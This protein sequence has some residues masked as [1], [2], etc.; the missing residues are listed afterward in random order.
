M[1]GRDK[2]NRRS[3]REPK[4]LQ[5]DPEKRTY[6][7]SP[8]RND[9]IRVPKD[10]H[11]THPVPPIPSDVLK[12]GKSEIDKSNSGPQNERNWQRVPTLHKRSAQDLPRRKSSKKRKEDHDR[13][14]E[15]KAM[16][17]SMPTR[18][19][20][21][22]GVAGRPMKRE[23]KKMR[24]GLGRN[25]TNPSSDISL[26]VPESVHSS[27]SS[28]SENHTSY[29]LKGIDLLS[30]RPT[31]R[32]SE[33]PHNT[34]LV[35]GVDSQRSAARRLP[36]R[37]QISEEVLNANKR[38]DDLADDLDA[39]SLR[40][41][42]E[43]DQRR[44]ERKKLS[45]QRRTERKIAKKA[46]KQRLEEVAAARAGNPPPKNMERGVL[47]REVVGLGIDDAPS[48][49]GMKSSDDNSRQQEKRPADADIEEPTTTAQNP[50]NDFHRSASLAPTEEAG[51]PVDEEDL[52]IATAQVARLS[53]ASMSS[54]SSPR[55]HARGASNISEMMDLSN[56]CAPVEKPEP[57]RKVS[58]ETNIRQHQSWTAFFR[59]NTKPKRNSTPTSFS[60][61]SRET[62]PTS[63]PPTSV[64]AP[65]ASISTGVPKRTMSRFREDLP[66]L[67]LSP[68]DSRVQSPEA[69]IVPPIRTGY[70]EK[71]GGGRGSGENPIN[72]A[73]I[74]RHDT[75]TSG[76]RS[77]E[78]ASRNRNET[79]TSGHR[80]DIP[81]PEPS[82]IMS[83]SLASIDSEGSW[84]SG[85]PRASSKHN[86]ALLQPLRDSTSSLHKRFKEYGESQEELGIAEDEYFSRLTPGPEEEFGKVSKRRASGNPMPSS[87]EE[88]GDS[89]AS[90]GG[91]TKWGAVG[92]QPTVVHHA[93]RAKSREVLL[94]DYENDSMSE[95]RGETPQELFDRKS[96]GFEGINK[97]LPDDP[98]ISRASSVNLSKGHARHISAGSA[99]LLDLKPRVSGESKRLSTERP[100]KPIGAEV[101]EA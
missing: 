10:I 57:S 70:P 7:F 11:R 54:P 77:L 71:K 99:R 18:A 44:R 52:M 45:D 51:S 13:E 26:P 101:Q 41:L 25:F 23:S 9:T 2:S 66:E 21:E 3:G 20:T 1:N 5:R 28:S 14:A 47:G 68:P 34:Q 30:P 64:Y 91:S 55:G 80:S 78:Q 4:K 46:E 56:T 50:F 42:M 87:D 59:R 98:A 17:A 31:I 92:R 96:Y 65:R 22:Y 43:R 95:P 48:S 88:D 61:T 84:L 79:P 63:Q 6:S 32:Y 38:I 73:S 29:I 89:V 85:R 16:S 75:P 67:P 86:S 90:P 24:M 97:P 35:R 33:N 81:S 12:G 83:Q 53:R 100:V 49:D 93:S 60:N 39:G 74:R 40:E 82:A 8:G 19:A 69:D 94:N 72:E 58:G 76:Y 62:T 15:I 36:D 27:M 37:E